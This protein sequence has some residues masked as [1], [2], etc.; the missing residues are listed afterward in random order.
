M[1][2]RSVHLLTGLSVFL[3]ACG[4][5]NKTSGSGFGGSASGMAILEASNG[6]GKLLPHTVDELDE[7]GVP[8]GN[9]FEIRSQADLSRITLNSPLKAPVLWDP[10][11][12]LPDRLPGNHFIYARF[13][14]A[15]DIDSVIDPN[16][17]ASKFLTGAITVVSVD[18]LTGATTQID[19]VPFVGGVT[20][21]PGGTLQ[22][23]VANEG[24]LP[25]GRPVALD[26]GGGSF[27]GDGF[28]GTEHAVPFTGASQ[29]VQPNTFV[30]VADTNGDLTDHETFP[31]GLQLQMRIT[32]GTRS[33]S[34]LS[35]VDE[36]VAAS[37]V[38]SDTVAPEVLVAGQFQTPVIIP[39]NGDIDVDPETAIEVF[40]TEPLQLLTLGP[41][42]DGTPPQLSS[43]V[44]LQFGPSTGKVDVPFTVRPYSV[45]DMT[46]IEL[47]P[48]YSFPGSGPPI[49]G[50]TCANFAQIDII[51]NGGQFTDLVGNPNTFSP[52]TFFV[53]DEGP[54]LVNAPVTPD[55][56]Y[57]GRGGSEQAISVIDLNGFGQGC[58]NPSYDPLS[59]IVQGSSNFPNNPNVAIQGSLLVPPLAPGSCTF[60]G[61]SEGIF[62][63]AKD[64][65]LSDKL[66]T[67]PLLESVGDM[68]LGRALDNTF[69]NAQPF[70]C[71]AGGGNI[72]AQTGLKQVTV[73][74]GGASTLIPQSANSG[75]F[76]IKTEFG[77]E[78]LASWAPHPNPPPLVFPPP[79]QAPLI[80]ALE[81]TSVNVSSG[82]IIIGTG[83]LTNLLTPG[84]KP[85]G[86]PALNVPPDGLISSEQNNFFQGPSPPQ[87]QITACGTYMMRQQIGHF[88]YVVDRV[89]GELVVLNSNRFTI[90]DRIRL[91]DPTSL[92][93][94]PNLDVIA[95]TNQ[96][97]N[98]VSFIDIN[99]ASSTFH[100]VIKTTLVGSGPI[101]IA[102]T[103]DNEDILVCN[104]RENTLSVISA[105]DFRVRKVARNQLRS[106]FEVTITPRQ[107]QFAFS[108]NVY[109]AYILNGDGSVAI[110][111]SG[112][113][114]I[115]GWGFD[116]TVGT[117]PFR[118]AR[119]KAIQADQNSTN[120]QFW[121][122]HEN[123]LDK[124][125]RPTGTPGGA[126]TLVGMASGTQGQVSL[127][128]SGFGNP[129][130]RDIQ[131]GVFGT[132]EE[133]ENGLTGIPVDLAFDNMK[134]RT[135]LTNTFN[136]F[137][138]GQGRSINGKSIVKN[139][140]GFTTANSP[141]FLFLAVPD[142]REGPG[143]ID[144]IDIGSGL[145]RIDTNSFEDGIQ[146]I[147][148]PGAAIVMDY[149]RQ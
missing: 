23:W 90:L 55:A 19:G 128:T 60:D 62:T 88:M 72:C 95:V 82:G 4:G 69:N 140:N 5:S 142:S 25:G 71:Q 136:Q 96:G 104:Q 70:G 147:P 129:R 134:N 59:P 132:V 27:P 144:V 18:P 125:G 137:S 6:F 21:G 64:S 17:S 123:P 105:F 111:E 108:R 42:D 46:H 51:V 36:G 91:P 73:A 33:T 84:S 56:V 92:A 11:P 61:G 109:F 149:L 38:G 37:T 143:V 1:K 34:G 58:G 7:L 67:F 114:G 102:W 89:A 10:M 28:P 100:T 85:L 75:V 139:N 9:I 103:P 53:T 77:V 145:R 30:F 121:I 93:I 119:P 115:N 83:G 12:I 124:T 133:R 135:A 112:P 63:L 39:G 68:M 97:A 74:T 101:G 45:F 127:D 120:S 47:T 32:S 31:S 99:P 141:Q 116:N 118:F 107:T 81:P 98:Q 110:F 126:A 138:A 43:S 106:P 40:F 57:V 52:N 22:Q 50:A 87:T 13:S 41:L 15:I 26:V 80:G 44:Q 94:S 20:A 117:I 65:S 113:G 66:A 29:L 54:G 24:G 2:L 131:F 146:S 76:S 14:Q 78:N 49:P 16:S 148:V 122:L 35:I 3:V 79:C 86:V 130:I 48:S 8:T